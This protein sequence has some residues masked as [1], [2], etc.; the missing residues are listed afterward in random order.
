MAATTKFF[1]SFHRCLFGRRPV[2][3]RLLLQR[4]AREADEL[5]LRQLHTLFD[6]VLPPSLAANKAAQG[7]NNRHRLY[8]PQVTLQ[9]FLSQTLD[10]DGSCRRAVTRLQTLCSAL[11]LAL[12]DEDPGA[13]FYFSN[14]TLS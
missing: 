12:P 3:E 1:P 8:T 6:E 10:A 4:K 9:A 13:Y 2:S 11:G 7:C 14:T 5:C